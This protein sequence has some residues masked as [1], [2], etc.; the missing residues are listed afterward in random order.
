VN[1]LPMLETLGKEPSLSETNLQAVRLLLHH[2]TPLCAIGELI[3]KLAELVNCV[4]RAVEAQFQ[5]ALEPD[6]R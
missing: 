4:S 6:Q 3:S 5:A 1:R 2:Q